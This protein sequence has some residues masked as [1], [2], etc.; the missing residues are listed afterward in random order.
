MSTTHPQVGAYLDD[1]ARMLSDV[2]PSERDDILASVREHLDVEIGS[3]DGGD[4]V[5]HAAL[6]RLG[7]PERVAAE[8]RRGDPPASLHRPLLPPTTAASGTSARVAV[9][10]TLL[11]TLPLLCLALWSRV[12]GAGGFVPMPSEVL[13]L[14]PMASPVW[15]LGLVCT[16]VAPGLTSRTRLR[17]ALVGPVAFAATVTAALW[18]SPEGLSGTV[19]V[20]LLATV[21]VGEAVVARTAWR[22]ARA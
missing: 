20:V 11:A 4:A 10:T 6:L 21:G 17:L 16:L 8:A 12:L 1:L 15:L 18:W 13:I 14:V 19:C 9:V 5:V 22:Q 2:D 3:G 7:P